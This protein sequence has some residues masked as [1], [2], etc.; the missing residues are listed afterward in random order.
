MGTIIEF[1]ADAASRRPA[2]GIDGGPRE[3]GS[4][5]AMGVVLILPVVRIER[6]PDETS[7]GRGPEEGTAPGRRRR[8]R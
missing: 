4:R 3:A 7:G 8:R 5:H 1:P 6:E 2:S